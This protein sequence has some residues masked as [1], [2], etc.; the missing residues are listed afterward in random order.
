VERLDAVAVMDVQVDVEHAQTVA[1]RPGD[2]QGHV[3]V[4]AETARPRPHGV[5]QP[6][7]GVVRVLDVAAQDRLDRPDR[8]ARNRAAASCM[9]AKAGSSPGPMPA[10]RS[11]G[12]GREAAHRGDVVGRVEP[13]ELVV[14]RGL[15]RQPGSAPTARSSSIPGPKRLGLSGCRGPKS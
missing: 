4:D 12:I 15:G 3:V 13:L 6:A 7:A 5:V 11:G 1:P 9:P 10:W 8:T 14:G 2:R